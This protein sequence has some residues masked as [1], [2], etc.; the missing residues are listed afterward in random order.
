MQIIF[1]KIKLPDF[2]KFDELFC[3]ERGEKDFD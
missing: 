2:I 1:K 3:T